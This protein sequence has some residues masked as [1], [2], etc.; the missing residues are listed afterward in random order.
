MFMHSVTDPQWATTEA[1]IKAPSVQN[2]QT[3]SL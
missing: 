1:E 3:F 2:W